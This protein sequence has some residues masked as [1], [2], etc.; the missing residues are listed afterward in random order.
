[1]IHQGST[2][3]A[4]AN[5]G[6]AYQIR[7][8]RT[9][10]W[11]A[12]ASTFSQSANALDGSG[13]PPPPATTSGEQPVGSSAAST[14]E[15]NGVTVSASGY[16]SRR[17]DTTSRIVVPHEELE[18]FGDATLADAL[19]RMPGVTVSTGAPGK[20]GNVS[21]RGMGNG[22]TQILLNGQKAPLGFDLESLTPEMIES[23]E[24]IRSATADM[25]AEGI[26]G[27][28]NVTLR[29]ASAG[30][31]NSIKLSEATSR[32]LYSPGLTWQAT[33]AGDKLS[34]VWTA[35]LAQ[36]NYLIT[37]NSLQTGVDSVGNENLL[38]PG[39][40]HIRGR[41]NSISMAPSATYRLSNG[42]KITLETLIEA[43]RS[44]ASSD[45]DYRTLI[46]DEVAHPIDHQYGLFDAAQ[47]RADI[48]WNHAFTQEGGNLESKV[49]LTTN[50][51][52][53]DFREHAYDAAGIL[54]LDTRVD[55]RVRGHGVNST[56]KYTLPYVENHLLEVGWDGGVT[57][58][59]ERRTQ[60][61]QIVAGV[62]PDNSSL[63]FDARVARLA[64]YAQDDWTVTKVWSLYYG[65]RVEQLNTR[66]S[67]D[68]FT[69]VSFRGRVV[70][71]VV[72]SLWKFPGGSKDQLR[73]AFSRTYNAPPIA[74]LVPRPYTTTNNT[75]LN[76]DTVGNPALRPELAVGLDLSFEHYWKDDAMIS[77]G[78]YARSISHVLRTETVLVDGRWIASP[79]NG[80]NAR[81]WG[82]EMD[83]HF[84]LDQLI[85]P[86]PHIDV[87][88]NAARNWSIV[89]DVPG[90]YNRINDQ[91]R[92]NSTVELE[93]RFSPAWNAGI[94]YT[95][96]TGG[97]VRVAAHQLDDSAARRA[98][99]IYALWTL[100][101]ATSLRMSV[102]NLLRQDFVSGTEYFDNNGAMKLTTRRPSQATARIDLEIKL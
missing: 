96:K 27:T 40:F 47:V 35:S 11:L 55:S 80:G 68:D 62:D 75:A 64:L 46:G 42:D 25:R 14:T 93:Y 92:V 10:F 18:K 15:L 7:V 43:S 17:D 13:N 34:Y 84:F 44:T 51:Q 100:S 26:A 102:A 58:R 79:F 66:S 65:L 2:E 59:S 31:N 32:G 97:P 24:I 23:V 60:T 95:F 98:L 89:D 91:I 74:Q 67:G 41:A 29:K 48:G 85:A 72:Q 76:P 82:V 3:G 52:N 63:S 83:T 53:G 39:E 20:P 99:D 71:P 4:A 49:T 8:R 19:K 22:Y 9:L 21:L 54:N 86:A 33:K 70:S 5:A 50:G 12:M 90:P 6:R 38:R 88:F 57:T 78:P 37:E 36:R 56:G 45:N 61:G 101:K 73:L 81:A 94:S 1:M 28:I 16:D 30:R 87:R 69:A 77:V